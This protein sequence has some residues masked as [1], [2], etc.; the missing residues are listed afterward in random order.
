MAEIRIG[1]VVVRTFFLERK[2]D[3]Q[4][5]MWGLRK[6]TRLQKVWRTEAVRDSTGDKN[7]A[8]ESGDPLGGPRADKSKHTMLCVCGESNLA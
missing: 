7:A 1:S 5:E 2:Q 4:M 3:I 6:I 8:A